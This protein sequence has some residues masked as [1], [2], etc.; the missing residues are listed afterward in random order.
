MPEDWYPVYG[1]G[2]NWAEYFYPAERPSVGNPNGDPTVFLPPQTEALQT[3]SDLNSNIVKP[4]F[5]QVIMGEASLD[6]WDS[7]VEK[8]MSNGGEEALQAYTDLYA[9]C[10][11]PEMVYYTYLPAEHPEYTGKYLFDGEAALTSQITCD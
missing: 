6:D 10:G 2:S 5:T 3:L 7:I 1:V 4:Y 9:A 11:S 8:W